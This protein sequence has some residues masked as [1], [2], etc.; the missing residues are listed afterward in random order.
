MIL[1]ELIKEQNYTVKEVITILKR[2]PDPEMWY[3]NNGSQVCKIAISLFKKP[4]IVSS[5]EE[6]GK[7]NNT[8]LT[9]TYLEF[10]VCT[11]SDGRLDWQFLN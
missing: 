9:V 2:L 4:R 11:N 3:S 1:Q 10:R 7:V 5:H 8:Y 6:G